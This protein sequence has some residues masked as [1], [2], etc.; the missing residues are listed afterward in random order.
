MCRSRYNSKSAY[1]GKLCYK[2]HKR[3]FNKNGALAW[4]YGGWGGGGGGHGVVVVVEPKW[5]PQV[6]FILFM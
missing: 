6:T 5:D 1:T 4:R 3:T 2:V